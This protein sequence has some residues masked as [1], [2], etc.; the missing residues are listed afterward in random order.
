MIR[1]VKSDLH[2][3]VHDILRNL[4]FFGALHLNDY[5]ADSLTLHECFEFK[6]KVF[7]HERTTSTSISAAVARDRGRGDL[8]YGLQAECSEEVEVFRHW[9]A[10]AINGTR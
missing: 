9:E 2:D 4:N 6:R 1:L 8:H 5:V 3:R 10:A 7:L